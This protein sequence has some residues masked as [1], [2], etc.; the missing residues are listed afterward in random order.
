MKAEIRKERLR[1]LSEID[2]IEKAC[3]GC[4]TRAHFN[5]LKDAT[6]LIQACRE[7]PVFADLSQYGERLLKLSEPRKKISIGTE[8]S[9]D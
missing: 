7:C 5:N 6:G 4:P 2:T 9:I 1:L 3:E 8:E